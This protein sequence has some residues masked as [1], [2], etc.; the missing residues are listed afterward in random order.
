MLHGASTRFCASPCKPGRPPPTP[1]ETSRSQVLKVLCNTGRRT[2]VKMSSWLAAPP[3]LPPN[4]NRLRSPARFR[5]GSSEVA[6]CQRLTPEHF[7]FVLALSRHR[8]SHR[9]LFNFP[10][11]WPLFSPIMRPPS[12]KQRYDR[13]ERRL[14]PDRL[15]RPTDHGRRYA[16]RC[17]TTGRSQPLADPGRSA[18][19]ACRSKPDPRLRGS[20]STGMP[21]EPRH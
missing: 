8:C 2:S 6:I 16:A 17:G 5:L 4:E 20:R 19:R 15:Q 13:P 7:G 14:S 12:Y 3:P 21:C 1:L 9:R 10:D 11:H 18:D